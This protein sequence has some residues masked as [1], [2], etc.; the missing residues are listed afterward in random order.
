MNEMGRVIS[1]L[2]TAHQARKTQGVQS[3]PLLSLLLEL[4]NGKYLT[5]HSR[6]RIVGDMTAF[7]MVG[8]RIVTCSDPC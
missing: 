4:D 1:A 8:L 6:N 3:R 7:T 2:D 5:A